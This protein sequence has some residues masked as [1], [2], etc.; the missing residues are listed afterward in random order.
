MVIHETHVGDAPFRRGLTVT[1]S[2]FLQPRSDRD[3]RWRRSSSG[4]NRPIRRPP[5]RMAAPCPR[6]VVVWFTKPSRARRIILE[7]RNL[8]AG[9]EDLKGHPAEFVGG[10][11]AGQADLLR[12]RYGSLHRTRRL[13]ASW[14]AACLARMAFQTH[15]GASTDSGAKL[16]APASTFDE[17]RT[18]AAW[19]RCGRPAGSFHRDFAAAWRC[20]GRLDQSRCGV[21]LRSGAVEARRGLS[22][23]PDRITAREDPG[24]PYH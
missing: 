23:C 24:S 12:S 1:A 18:G 11:V 3:Q 21:P 2:P 19:P 5:G 16:S 20:R 10:S 4:P 17:S 14:R 22:A 6:A 8:A 7:G 13:K 9:G 15:A